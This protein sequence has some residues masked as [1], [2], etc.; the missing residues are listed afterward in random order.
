MIDWLGIFARAFIVFNNCV[1]VEYYNFQ[2][3]IFCTLYEIVDHR[4]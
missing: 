1:S 2:Y 3:I 4:L